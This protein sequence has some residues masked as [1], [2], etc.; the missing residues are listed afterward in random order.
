MTDDIEAFKDMKIL[1][2]Y[3]EKYKFIKY[4]S[5]LFILVGM[6]VCLGCIL[7]GFYFNKK[8]GTENNIF[9]IAGISTG[10]IFLVLNILVSELMIML[11]NNA[12]NVE[13]LVIYTSRT[14]QL[15]N[16]FAKGEILTSTAKTPQSNYY[17][18]EMNNL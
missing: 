15:L 18:E 3:K 11:I 13:R 5:W 6:I 9:K 8:Y 2:D 12:N 4:T 1:K 7:L 10:F 14:N 17:N 16:S